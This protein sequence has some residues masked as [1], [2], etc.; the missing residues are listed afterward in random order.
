[1]ARTYKKEASQLTMDS[2]YDVKAVRSAIFGTA[3]IRSVVFIVKFPTQRI[4][5]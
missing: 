1:M 2:R 3:G 4:K 5:M